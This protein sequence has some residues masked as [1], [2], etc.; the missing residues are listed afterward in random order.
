M[1]LDD[2][3]ILSLL[4]MSDQI[5]VLSFYVGI[6]PEEMANPQPPWQIEIRNGVREIR[7]QV[8]EHQ[9]REHW[10]AVHERLDALE[11]QIS[12]LVDAKAPGRGRAMFVGIGNGETHR[13]SIQVPFRQRVIMD[14]M[15]FVRPLVAA[16]DEGRSAG[17][18]VLHRGGL[19]LLEWRLGVAEELA[20]TTF[21]VGDAQFGGEKTGPAGDNPAL[22]Q[23]SVVHKERFEH[24]LDE[25]RQRLLRSTAA[26]VASTVQ[27]RGWDRLVVAGEP[28]LRQVFLEAAQLNDGTIVLEDDRLWETEPPHRIA[29]AAWPTLRSVHRQREHALVEV[30][31]DRALAGGAGALGLPDTLGALNEGRVEHL[32]FRS[33]LSASGFRVSQG[34]LLFADRPA[35][36]LS[37]GECVQEPLLVERM[38]ERALDTRARITPVDGEAAEALDQHGGVAALLRW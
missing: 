8:R 33:Q 2:A 29:E 32:L 26:D 1:S 38:I 34:G 35:A 6:T 17:V 21:T 22:A 23:Q 37:G 31:R 19:R 4:D 5:G 18:V 12:E 24:R 3:T 16:Q 25:H 27:Q 20:A 36:E 11:P 7:Q 13:V 10:K 28:R 30:A 14:H 15:P 9:P